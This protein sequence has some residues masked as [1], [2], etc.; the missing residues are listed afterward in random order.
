MSSETYTRKYTEEKPENL[1]EIYLDKYEPWYVLL[2]Q[3]WVNKIVNRGCQKPYQYEDL[4]KLSDDYSTEKTFPIFL[5]YY[6]ANREKKHLFNIMVGFRSG[7]YVSG[8]LAFAFNYIILAFAP[9]C[10]KKII[11]W[12]ADDNADD[13]VG[14]M[15]AGIFSFILLLHSWLIVKGNTNMSRA[16]VV[17]IYNLRT[18]VRWKIKRL[19]SAARKHWDTGKITSILMVD[20]FR[21]DTALLRCYHIGAAFGIF[22]YLTAYVILELGWVGLFA[23]LIFTI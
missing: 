23:P 9:F 17:I 5:E 10:M 2:M 20:I 6:L 8:W 1:R 3:T 19:S 18:L 4:Y 12:L 15:W 22:V 16:I 7:W 13:Y 11:G 14:W 21:M